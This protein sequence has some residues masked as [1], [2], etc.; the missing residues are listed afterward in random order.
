M[1]KPGEDIERMK[2][3]E[4]AQ[5][6]L[7]RETEDIRSELQEYLVCHAVYHGAKD[8][9]LTKSQIESTLKSIFGIAM[10][11]DMIKE[12]LERLVS[13]KAL[14]V[15]QTPQ[16]TYLLSEDRQKRVSSHNKDYE[17][18]RNIVTKELLDRIQKAHSGATE[19]ASKITEVFFCTISQIFSRY[20][21]VCSDQITGAKGAVQEIASLPDFQQICVECVKALASPTLRKKVKDELR[22]CF[23][24]PSK[25]FIYFLHSMAQAYTV[26]QILVLDPKLQTLVKENF[27]KKKLYLDTNVI[28]SL[29]CVAEEHDTVMRIVYLTN[30]LG[31]PMVFTPETRK[32]FQ[33]YLDYS[34]RLYKRI[35]IH[36]KSII[37][38]TEPLMANPFIRSYWIESAEKQLEWTAF[39]TRMEGFQEFLEDKFSITIEATPKEIWMDTEYGELNRA[40]YLADLDKHESAIAHD[41][42]HLLM[43]KKKREEETVDELGERSYFLTRDYT[44]NRAERIVYRDSRIP[45]NLSI[46]VWSQMILPFLSP[47]LVTEE[48]S[49]AYMMVLASKF[50]SLTRS[51]DPKDLIDVMGIWMDDPS[52][53]T[54]LLRRIVGNRFVRERLQQL[55]SKPKVKS[56]QVARMID[57]LMSLAISSARKRH[58]KQASQLKQRYDKEILELK[59]DV[60]ELKSS[61][62]R[63]KKIH[64]PLFLTGILMF[65]VLTG[66]ALISGFQKLVL[67]DACYYALTFAGIAFITSSVFG[68]KALEHIRRL[69]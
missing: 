2:L 39:I 43:I 69:K 44:L 12:S 41:A 22:A 49:K 66:L 48:A 31:V 51:V 60:E 35:P 13:K 62:E 19:H 34:K 42:Y 37:N 63:S 61:L 50:P 18:L 45:S 55:R 32:E 24:K 16:T 23:L 14:I 36:K 3:L 33:D 10:P 40:V 57:P 20:G 5:F 4:L 17:A 27:C 52:I 25:E 6:V 56:S 28:L 30:K 38:K 54:E 58:E 65:A 47:K 53:T 7:N 9:G 67:S 59:G 64:K 68:S 29:M 8:Q 15:Q 11:M 21:S 46:D 26:L 1:S